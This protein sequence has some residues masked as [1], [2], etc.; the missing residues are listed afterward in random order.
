MR[1]LKHSPTFP[2]PV[3]DTGVLLVFDTGMLLVFDTGMLIV[4]K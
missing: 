2:H 1:R 3:L 4:W